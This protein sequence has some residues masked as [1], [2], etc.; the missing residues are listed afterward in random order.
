M[1][2]DLWLVGFEGFCSV[3]IDALIAF[4]EEQEEEC[5]S[6]KD[7]G[8]D[9]DHEQQRH[10]M[11]AY[12]QSTPESWQRFSPATIIS[13]ADGI[14]AMTLIRIRLLFTASMPPAVPSQKLEK[15]TQ[16]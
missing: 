4:L 15:K 2:L 1:L 5:R 6:A 7:D 3:R 13:A 16:A 14:K 12:H 8:D 11:M 9:V 10:G